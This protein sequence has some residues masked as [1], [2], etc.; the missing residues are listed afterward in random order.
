VL[1]AAEGLANGVQEEQR[2]RGKSR[3]AEATPLHM[4]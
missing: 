4:S 1:Q 2:D 3:R